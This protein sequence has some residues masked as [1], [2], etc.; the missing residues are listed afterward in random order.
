LA[1]LAKIETG[2]VTPRTIDVARILAAL[3]T[4]PS[5]AAPPA[6][7]PEPLARRATS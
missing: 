3:A 7:E 4:D 6:A 1:K 5:A 2:R